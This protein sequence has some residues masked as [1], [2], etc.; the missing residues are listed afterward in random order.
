M[1]YWATILFSQTLGTALGDWM[2]DPTGVGLGYEGGALV[3]AAGAWP[4]VA[5]AAAHV[6]LRL[7]VHRAAS[8][9]LSTGTTSAWL[10]P[11]RD[12]LSL[13]LWAAAFTGRTVRWGPH[14][15]AVDLL[16]RLTRR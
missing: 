4:A 15:F 16:G 9:A 6:A 11:V 3:L 2:A 5:V 13:V 7:A 14:R 10:L 1:F 12:L 8:R